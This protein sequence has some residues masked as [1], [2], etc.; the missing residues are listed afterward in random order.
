MLFRSSGIGEAL[1]LEYAAPGIHLTLTGRDGARI[2]D[3]GQRCEA[4]GAT[5]EAV[6]LDVTERAAMAA[7]IAKTDQTQPLDLVIANAGISGGSGGDGEDE[8]QARAIFDVNFIGVLNT[9]WPAINAMK[10]RK[11]GHIAIVSSI[12]GITPMPGAPAYS[13]SKVAVKAYGE[14]LNGALRPDGVTVT[15]ICP[16]FVASRITAQN[17]FPMPLFMDAPKAARRIRRGDRKRVV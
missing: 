12:A 7:L 13:A 3:V 5:V 2:A 16:G 17:D 4:Q 6:A 14:A 8:A 15:T 1:A 10:P 9:I 11:C